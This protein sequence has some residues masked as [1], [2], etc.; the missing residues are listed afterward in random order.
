VGFRYQPDRAAIEGVDFEA[1]VGSIT[2]I[3]GPTGSGKSTLMA[4]LLRLFDPDCGAIEVDGVDIRRYRLEDLRS[5]IAIALQEN[6]LFGT[7]IRENIRYA[8]PAASDELVR[9]AARVACAEEFIEA[10]PE[11]FDTLLGEK[12]TKLSSGQR[13]R[14]SIARAVLK[15]TNVL[16]LDEPTASLDAVTE[17]VVLR[18]LAEWG[19][20]RAI[21]LITHR[22]STIRRADRVVFLRDGRAIES[23]T[24]AELM[25]RSEG[26]YRS[27]IELEEAPRVERPDT[28]ASG[29]GGS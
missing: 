15:D 16:I 12:G 24:H 29:G 25:S 18:N 17:S 23:G 8:V 9:R 21:F 20:D 7:T 26:A 5:R 10:Q 6:I 4:L 19:K 13:Q 28:A 1:R 22:L 27:L 14:L 3:V 2:A 11:G